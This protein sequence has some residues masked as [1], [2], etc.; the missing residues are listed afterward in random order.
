MYGNIFKAVIA[1]GIDK[2]RMISEECGDFRPKYCGYE[3]K[4]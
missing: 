3:M 1:F 4:E 2:I